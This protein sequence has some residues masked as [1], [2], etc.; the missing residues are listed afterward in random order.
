MD[1]T[2]QTS[3]FHFDRYVNGVLM[4]EGVTIE[5]QKTLAG[6]MR[7]AAR[8]ASR[9]PN[10]ET[11]VLVL[12]ALPQP[13]PVAWRKHLRHFTVRHQI[14]VLWKRHGGGTHGPHVE[15]MT[16]PEAKF[17]DFLEAAFELVEP[18][19]ASL[20]VPGAPSA[21]PWPEG[22][23]VIEPHNRVYNCAS[24]DCG[25]RVSIRMEHG[26]IGANYCEP[27]ARKIVNTLRRSPSADDDLI[28]AREAAEP[29]MMIEGRLYEDD[30]KPDLQLRGEPFYSGAQL[31]AAYRHGYDFALRTERARRGSGA[32]EVDASTHEKAMIAV[33]ED[34]GTRHFTNRMG[35]ARAVIRVYLLALDRIR[36]ATA[37]GETP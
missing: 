8:L 25:Q 1:I 2:E 32:G 6:A 16:I 23:F 14:G 7:E 4:A 5:R 22:F 37:S 13:E 10:N 29:D 35:E 24:A 21:E 36:A 17:G 26:G 27:C 31:R 3:P 19:Y 30:R 9:G 33:A 11:P 20:P 15:T 34:I 12:A 28:A 18:L